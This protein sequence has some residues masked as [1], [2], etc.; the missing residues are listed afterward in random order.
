MTK[1]ANASTIDNPQ[2]LEVITFDKAPQEYHR[3]NVRELEREQKEAISKLHATGQYQ[4]GLSSAHDRDMLD[5]FRRVMRDGK[6]MDRKAILK[7]QRSIFKQ[8][9]SNLKIEAPETSAEASRQNKELT[10]NLKE[11]AKFRK[12]KK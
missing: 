12:M 8:P 6:T 11:T 9:K 10:H 1:N 3:I 4:G 7:K 5:Y 2:D